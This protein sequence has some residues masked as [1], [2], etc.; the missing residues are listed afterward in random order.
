MPKH[1]TYNENQIK[2]IT[3]LYL[4][5]PNYTLKKI[6]V[7]VKG[8]VS[9]ISKIISKYNLSKLLKEEVKRER[10]RIIRKKFKGIDLG[11]K[12]RAIYQ[13]KLLEIRKKQQIDGKKKCSICKKI[14]SLNNF[15]KLPKNQQKYK[16]LILYTSQCKNCEQKRTQ[17]FKGEKS[18]TIEGHSSFLISGVKK[19][20]ND[21]KLRL[22]ITSD[23]IVKQFYKQNGRCYYTN[24][25]MSHPSERKLSHKDGKIGNE[26]IVSVDRKIPE[27]G[28]TKQNSVLC[29]W[30]VNNMKQHYTYEKFLRFCDLIIKN[31]K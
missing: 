3:D 8:T 17:K 26:N 14:K 29:C 24:I 27:K 25:K 23:W 13:K 5:N 7:R 15:L 9:G 4:N 30:F 22:E 2:I 19:R 31:K 20:A 16:G 28:Y 11:K 10:N 21:K 1:R 18:S 6:A 12:G